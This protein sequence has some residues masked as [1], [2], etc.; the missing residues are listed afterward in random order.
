MILPS[1]LDRPVGFILDWHPYLQRNKILEWKWLIILG[2]LYWALFPIYWY[3]TTYKVGHVKYWFLLAGK[4]KSIKMQIDRSTWILPK[5]FLHSI[6]KNKLPLTYIYIIIFCF[7]H[8]HIQSIFFG[9]IYSTFI[10]YIVN[11]CVSFS[12]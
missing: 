5:I 4:I 6:Q 10:H 9:K 8:I 2:G 12:K 11:W 3:T 7:V 1:Y